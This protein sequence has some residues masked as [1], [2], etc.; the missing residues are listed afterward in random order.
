[1]ARVAYAPIAILCS[2]HRGASGSAISIPTARREMICEED[3]D[4]AAID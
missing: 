1:M 4:N 2:A 3:R